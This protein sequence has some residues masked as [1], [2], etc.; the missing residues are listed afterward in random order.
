MLGKQLQRNSE[1]QPSVDS[2]MTLDHLG[3]TR[4]ADGGAALRVLIHPSGYP[5][6]NISDTAMLQVALARVR[7]YWPRTPIQIHPSLDDY[8][9][10]VQCADLVLMSGAGNL[11]DS[12]KRHA[13]CRLDT[14]ELAMD[15]G[16]I[17][18]LVG[19]GVGPISNPVLRGQAARI[20]PKVNFIALRDGLGSLTLLTELGVPP[21]R[22]NITS[23]DVVE[24][25]HR[26]RSDS[27]GEALGVNIRVAGYSG[28]NEGVAVRL[29]AVVG[30]AADQLAAVLRPLPVAGHAEED[31]LRVARLVLQESLDGEHAQFLLM[32]PQCRVIVSSSYHA[33][34]FALSMGIPAVCIAGCDYYVHKFRGL[35]DQFGPACRVELTS[36][37]DFYRRVRVAIEA[38]WV[39]APAA[40]QAL[41][42]AAVRQIVLGKA[43]YRRLFAMVEARGRSSRIG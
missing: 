23:D 22:V 6:R 16:A 1:L 39:S 29:R 19:Q 26:A 41:L 32:L 36:H 10:A 43:A 28:L 42:R 11:N 8:L 40:R 15:C 31:D 5:C 12:F 25:A 18:A 37:P 27:C 7:A 14:L 4:R 17:T 33:A 21:S 24:L 38:T 30:A 13:L 9:S 3:R 35:A 2:I 20:L 34:V